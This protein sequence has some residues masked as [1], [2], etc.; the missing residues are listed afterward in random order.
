SNEV[1]GHFRTGRQR[2]DPCP[3]KQSVSEERLF[4]AKG[5]ETKASST[6][7]RSE[8]QS[9]LQKQTQTWAKE[10]GK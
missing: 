6:I 1:I 4:S 9:F 10:S 3:R 5:A 2:R 8:L 7:P